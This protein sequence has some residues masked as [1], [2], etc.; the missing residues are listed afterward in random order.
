VRVQRITQPIAEQVKGKHCQE[1]HRPRKEGDVR[2]LAN[3]GAAIRQRTTPGS[4]GRLDAK[5][6]DGIS[7]P[8]CRCSHIGLVS[9]SQVLQPLLAG[10]L[11]HLPLL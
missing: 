8:S 2:E 4:R 6:Q 1:D 5:P 10:V 11:C 7:L 9:P 3:Q